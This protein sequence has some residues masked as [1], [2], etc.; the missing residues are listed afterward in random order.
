MTD[1]P[2]VYMSLHASDPTEIPPPPSEP[3]YARKQITWDAA[4][5]GGYAAE[6]VTFRQGAAKMPYGSTVKM[7]YGS[8]VFFDV[9]PIGPLREVSMPVLRL[10][11]DT[12]QAVE[13]IELL[14]IALAQMPV[15]Q[16]CPWKVHQSRFRQRR[17][18]HR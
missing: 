13:Q 11:A 6:P 5:D 2:K 16:P 17:R 8:T 3:H 4:R 18:S 7:S 15:R 14:L 9:P 1:T 10:T 12:R